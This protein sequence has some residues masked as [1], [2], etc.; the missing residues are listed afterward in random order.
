MASYRLFLLAG[1]VGISLC[2]GCATTP[3]RQEQRVQVEQVCVTNIDKP[4]AMQIAEDVL[5]AMHF[6]I[7]KA[8]LD[9][10][11]I[12]TR[13]LSGAQFFEF[14]RSDNVGPFYAALANLHSI[15][16]IAEVRIQHSANGGFIRCDVQIQRLSVPEHKAAG[17]PGA[18][19]RR[20]APTPEQEKGITWIDL[21]KD[22]MLSTEILNRI[23]KHIL[24]R[25]SFLVSRTSDES[26]ATGDEK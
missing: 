12:R 20:L 2:A 11:L 24:A 21:G 13:P 17:S 7:E 8:D 5:T 15:R 10:G 22:T 3:A 6:A 14:W 26:Q 16:R 19:V 9:S 23:Q 18:P 1:C 25:R 4:Q